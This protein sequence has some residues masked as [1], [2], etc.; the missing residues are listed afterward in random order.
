MK[1]IAAY[2][3]S[4]RVSGIFA[5]N[6]LMALVLTGCETMPQKTVVDFA[7]PRITP[8]AAAPAAV[9]KPSNGSLYQAASYRPAFE[10]RRAR[11]VGDTV[12]IQITESLTASQVSSS[13]ANRDTTISSAISALPLQTAAGLGK[14]DL[15]ASSKNDFS[16]KGGT[17]SANTFAGTITATVVDVLPNGNLIVTGE[18]QIG[19]NHNVDVLRFSG[20]VDPRLLQPGSVIASTQVANVRVESRGRGPQGEAQTVGWLSRF[21]LS[22]HPF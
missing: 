12:T 11:L 6:F 15:G 20:T 21:F 2:A 22:F 17:Q 16:G 8:V 14:F 3:F 10:D 1:N 5:L 18:K 9:S 4:K 13:T 19:V 7:E